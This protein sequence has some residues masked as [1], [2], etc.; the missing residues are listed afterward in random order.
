MKVISLLK[1]LSV[2][3]ILTV[4]IVGLTV[5]V[6]PAFGGNALQAQADNTVESPQGIYYKG[7]PDGGEV[8][9]D[10]TNNEIFHKTKANLKSTVDSVKENLKTDKLKTPEATKY[11]AE[12]GKVSLNHENKPVEEAKNGIEKLAETITEKLNLNEEPPRST[13]EFLNETEKNVEKAVKPVTGTRKG[14]YN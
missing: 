7:T 8:R 2:R 13:K 12:P 9:S 6:M 10:S 4:F 5:F 1:N 11:K 14:Y 3:Q